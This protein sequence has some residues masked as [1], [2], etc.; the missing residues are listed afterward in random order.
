MTEVKHGTRSGTYKLTAPDAHGQRWLYRLD[1]QHYH[2][3]QPRPWV[4][5]A[6]R[7]WPVCGVVD[8]AAARRWLSEAFPG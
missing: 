2:P 7:E 6:G 1:G 8:D 5:V 4:V 3:T